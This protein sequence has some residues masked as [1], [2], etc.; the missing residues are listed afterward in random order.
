MWRPEK[1]SVELT[2]LFQRPMHKYAIDSYMQVVLYII[3]L[4]EIFGV[5]LCGFQTGKLESPLRV[6]SHVNK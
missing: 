4:L 2:P 5:S 6:L 3:V 1:N